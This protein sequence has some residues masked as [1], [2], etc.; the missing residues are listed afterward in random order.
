MY[1]VFY[2]KHNGEDIIFLDS[3]KSMDDAI[4]FSKT[5][6]NEYGICFLYIMDCNGDWVSF[7][8]WH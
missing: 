6:E 3:F 4:T 1:K 5:W 8:D 2:D 7:Y